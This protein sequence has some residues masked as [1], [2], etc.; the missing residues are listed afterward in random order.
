MRDLS[1]DYIESVLISI[2]LTD[3]IWLFIDRATQIWFGAKRAAPADAGGR[4]S[5][6][7]FS[8]VS[9]PKLQSISHSLLV[10]LLVAICAGSYRT[11]AGSHMT[12][13]HVF[14]KH[15][16]SVKIKGVMSWPEVSSLVFKFWSLPWT[17]G[18]NIQLKWK[19]RY[20][21][22]QCAYLEPSGMHFS[23]RRRNRIGLEIGN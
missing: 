10:N 9:P 17:N 13:R 5:V 12:A 16:M 14:L 15:S 7:L 11:G 21:P 22:I 3:H 2:I 18:P 20:S 4:R 6:R 23:D 19:L 8:Q 1:W